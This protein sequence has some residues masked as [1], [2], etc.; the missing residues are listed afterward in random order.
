MPPLEVTAN[1]SLW[2]AHPDSNREPKD[3]EFSKRSKERASA[4]KKQDD[5]GPMKGLADAGNKLSS[6]LPA[7]AEVEAVPRQAGTGGPQ[8]GA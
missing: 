3:Y 7:K 6:I 2:W 1:A 5:G 4:A 8:D